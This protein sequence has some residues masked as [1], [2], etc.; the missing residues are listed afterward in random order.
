MSTLV[1]AVVAGTRY[2]LTDNNPFRL[3]SI[4]LWGMAPG[5]LLETQG[6]EQHGTTVEGFRLDPRDVA[7]VIGFDGW[8][9]DLVTPRRTLTQIFQR[10][11]SPLSL[12]FT[13]AD[14]TV[15]QIDG[16]LLSGLGFARA[17]TDMN[18]MAAGAVVHCPDPT[19]YDPTEGAVTFELGAA[20]SAGAVP[21]PVPTAIGAST[22]NATTA[23]T[24]V[25]TWQ[26]LPNRIRISGP[27]TNFVLTNNTTGDV[28]SAKNAV[29]IA[30]GHYVD[31]DCRYGKA[32]AV[33]YT[34]ANWIANLTDSNDLT[35]FHF[36]P[37]PDAPGGINSISLTGSGV[38]SDTVVQ[39]TY[40]LR[41]LGA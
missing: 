22:I 20:S 36:A 23:V 14:G 40:Y 29:T 6:A 9:D 32:S 35:V 26:S 30:D 11:A 19:F 27:I 4:D 17:G 38:N 18:A 34:G 28:I 31:L 1:E 8:D 13:F 10:R 2:A 15:R 3:E 24:Y 39:I 25:G 37:D 16:H 7:L 12:C 33:D 5:H 21:T 41:Y